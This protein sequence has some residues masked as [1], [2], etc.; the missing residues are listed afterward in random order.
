LAWFVERYITHTHD[1]S[2]LE[3]TC[4]KLLTVIRQ[5]S[6]AWQIAY[7]RDF[8]KLTPIGPLAG[9]IESQF[10]AQYWAQLKPRIGRPTPIEI[11]T[12]HGR[13]RC[14]SFEN[15]VGILFG[16]I[17]VIYDINGKWTRKKTVSWDIM[18]TILHD[19]YD[20]LLEQGISID[21]QTVVVIY[22]RIQFV[23]DR[24][25]LKLIKT[26]AMPIA[27]PV[28]NSQY[29]M[30]ANAIL[31]EVGGGKFETIDTNGRL[32][33]F[34]CSDYIACV[35]IYTRKCICQYHHQTH[36]HTIVKLCALS[37]GR[38]L[39]HA[40]LHNTSIHSTYIL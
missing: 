28:D 15:Y 32:L 5:Y 2:A 1:L 23:Y 14:G 18:D 22:D 33:W 30:I 37:N 35:D 36:K 27:V 29:E 8:P 16:G 34:A 13:S 24:E 12:I 31:F 38:V 17:V 21:S 26:S 40:K 25:T 9:P 11:A 20:T 7:T 6:R 10:R 19:P 39:V 4:H 3:C